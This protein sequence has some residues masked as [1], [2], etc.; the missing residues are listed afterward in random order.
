MYMRSSR[1]RFFIDLKLIELYKVVRILETFLR[2]TS[3]LKS[4]VGR[5]LQM[6]NGS[7]NHAIT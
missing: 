1:L 4:K 5:G 3:K 2:R 7:T 6:I